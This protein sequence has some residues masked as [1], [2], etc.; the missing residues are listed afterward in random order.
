MRIRNRRLNQ[1][2]SRKITDIEIIYATATMAVTVIAELQ[3]IGPMVND[4]IDC[5]TPKFG[6]FLTE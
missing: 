6:V 4:G 2:T 5:N 3:I 1:K